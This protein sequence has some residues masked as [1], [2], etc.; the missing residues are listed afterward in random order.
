MGTITQFYK[1]GKRGTQNL[2][3][4]SKVAQLV[5][6]GARIQIQMAWFR[7]NM[8]H[9]ST[10]QVLVRDAVEAK[11]YTPNSIRRLE[12]PASPK[13]FKVSYQELSYFINLQST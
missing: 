2:N 7:T 5:N 8:L 11:R 4:S 13:K 10:R 12:K 3:K 1:G 9:A 6:V